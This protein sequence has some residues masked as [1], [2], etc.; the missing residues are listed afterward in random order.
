MRESAIISGY[1]WF[2]RPRSPPP[3]WLS[4]ELNTTR[5]LANYATEAVLNRTV[6][7]G[8]HSGKFEVDQ[9][10]ATY[11][12]F[13]PYF[14]FCSQMDRRNIDL[15][16]NC[17]VKGRIYLPGDDNI[18]S[19]KPNIT[20]QEGEA[21]KA[22]GKTKDPSGGNS[23]NCASGIGRAKRKLA[24]QQR[25]QER[26]TSAMDITKEDHKER[27]GQ[28]VT[29]NKGKPLSR[30]RRNKVRA[31]SRRNKKQTTRLVLSSTAED[32]EIEEYFVQEDQ[33]IFKVP[34]GVLVE[35][36]SIFGGALT[37]LKMRYQG[38]GH[39]L[40]LLLEED[41]VITDC[42]IRTLE[43]EN[44]VEF[45]FN[46]D[47]DINKVII[48]SEPLKEIFN[49]LDSTSSI[50][51]I[52]L[53]SDPPHLQF[54]TEGNAGDTQEKPPPVHPTEIR[55]SIS[56]SSVVELNTTSALANYATEAVLFILLRYQFSSVKSSF[57]SLA[58]SEKAS[59][60]I[61]EN[62]LLC[63]QYMIPTDAET[64]FIEYYV[65]TIYLGPPTTG[66]EYQSRLDHVPSSDA[67]QGA[68]LE[69]KLDHR[70]GRNNII[71]K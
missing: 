54:S 29:K 19:G 4:V 33:V 17:T 69:S 55:T 62:G 63:F 35:C 24:V 70:F 20:I 58:I 31:S 65:S 5:A 8:T 39:P 2:G 1:Q 44:P 21:E 49:D 23:N 68:D 37:I 40:T 46:A 34:L 61:D 9:G 30:Q 10:H 22:D 51:Q 6:S 42:N 48:K 38:Y 25:E 45:N 59:I 43:P 12:M 66:L 71:F 11:V 27:K 56:S 15:K 57:K 16:Q 13:A 3:P 64:C 32:G 60:R 53:S 50:L 41:G 28:D 36:L 52:I 26:H 67:G 14:Y 47:S 7:E 18:T